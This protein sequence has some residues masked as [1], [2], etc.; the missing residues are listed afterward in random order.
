MA[1]AGQTYKYPPSEDDRAGIDSACADGDGA[2]SIAKGG[3][4]TCGGRSGEGNGWSSTGNEGL[5]GD[6]GDHN[7]KGARAAKPPKLET[8]RV[9][10]KAAKAT[11]RQRQRLRECA[12]ERTE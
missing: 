4:G 9:T 12:G 6:G 1:T 8:T 3:T 10:V 2:S 11:G 7:Y 5:S